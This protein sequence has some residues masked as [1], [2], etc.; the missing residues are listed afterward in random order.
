MAKAIFLFA[1]IVGAAYGAIAQ[2]GIQSAD[3]VRQL[4]ADRLERIERSL[5]Q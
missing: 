1:V 4:Q 3:G 5:G 2:Q